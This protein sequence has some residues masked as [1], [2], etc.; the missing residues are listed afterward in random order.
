MAGRKKVVDSIDE[1]I[2]NY[3]LESKPI[4][5]INTG[6]ELLNCVVGGGWPL[7]RIVNVVGDKST[8]KTLLAIEA[9]ANF[10]KQFP[11]GIPYYCEAEAAF[12]IDYAKVLGLP[13]KQ[14]SFIEDIETIED[15]FTELEKVIKKHS[16][17]ETP[18]LFIL[19]SLD[20]LSD[21]AEK[22][23]DISEGSFGAEKAK[24]M[25]QL[26]RRLVQSLKR[27]KI[28]LFI[29]SQV[30]DNVGISFGKKHG[31]SGGKALDFY[32]S[33]VLWLAETEKIYK[34]V[35]GIKRPIGIW[36]KAK[37]DKNKISMPYRECEFPILFAYGINDVEANMEFIQSVS[38]GIDYFDE[39]FKKRLEEVKIETFIKNIIEN[40]DVEWKIKINEVTKKVWI[41]TEEGFMPKG[42]KY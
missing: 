40:N 23:R 38:G 42:K 16:Q 29:I 37:C 34:T 5:F 21:K 22:E 30:R 27:T 3:L 28:C 33:I 12:D 7:G 20:A 17:D 31:R 15:L 32:A 35:K 10:V 19:D 41:D 4:D 6:C 26:F 9:I 2:G 39:E 11:D 36:D 18:A 25:S 14:V 24:K 13:V 1:R 8:G